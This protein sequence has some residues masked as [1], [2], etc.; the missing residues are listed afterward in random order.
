MAFHRQSKIFE[1]EERGWSNGL[2][3]HAK[4]TVYLIDQKE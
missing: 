4:F 1:E 3:Q 2:I